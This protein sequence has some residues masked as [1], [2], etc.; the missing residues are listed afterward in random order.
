MF[1]KIHWHIGFPFVVLIL[2]SMGFLGI[3]L[4]N[5]VRDIQTENL[6]TQLTR[7][8]R[9]AAEAALPA[10]L[11]TAKLNTIDS[12]AKSLGRNLDARVTIIALD[13]AVLGDSDE[14]PAA[15]ENHS[16]RPEVLAALASG[17]GT[18][19]RYSTTLKLQMMYVAVPIASQGRVLGSAR[20]ALPL[21]AV[22]SSVG[23]LTQTVGLAM[24]LAA[25][26]TV[27]AAV[28]V[29]RATT[30]PIREVTR[31]ARRIAAGD[32]LQKI[33]VP[34]TDELGQ[35][36]RTFNQMSLS[37]KNTLAK[38]N[39]ES[40]KL[41]TVLGSMADGVIMTDT[42]GAVVLANPAAEGI[43]GFKEENARGRSLIEVIR[44]HEVDGLLKSCLRAGKQQSAQFQAGTGK[45]F[46]RVIAM[47]L[48][49]GKPSGVLLLFQDLTELEHLQTMRREFVGNVS[50]ELMTPLSGIKAIVE[51]LQDSALDDKEAAKG[52]L[53]MVN[54]EVD[55]MTQ[56]VRELIELSRI[57]SGK[58][59]LRLEPVELNSLIEGVVRQMSVQAERQQVTLSSEFPSG[60]LTVSADRER[61]QQVLINLVHNAIK[62]TPAGGQVVVSAGREGDSA[63][64][65]VSDTGIGISKVDL[66]RVF[67]RFYKADKARSGS[68]TGLGLAIA[69]HVV[70]AHGGEI[71]AQS[72]EGK[73]ST[74]SFKLPMRF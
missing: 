53:K 56:M 72:E 54:G 30:H 64:V 38:I 58:A 15:M 67:E 23:R 14:D 6:R 66:P 70:Q 62:F 34:R 12:L 71:R 44:D 9:T 41:A 27:L 60:P 59:E 20:V 69:K 16:A 37:L 1:G 68:G 48:P 57:E 46:L 2:A 24:A 74:F 29:A 4:T 33:P 26:L 51:T 43:F 52:F 5:S 49:T 63:V 47:P 10:I 25:L 65:S 35:L 21:T 61:V 45:R 32:I 13:G 50:H 73:G 39:S 7:G 17:I 19:T 3:Y 31:A 28:F 11:D 55:R 18:N 8:A 40:T 22:E 36:A 42:G